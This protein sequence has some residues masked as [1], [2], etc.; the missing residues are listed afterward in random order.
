ML[1]FLMKFQYIK[2]KTLISYCDR[3]LYS[4]GIIIIWINYII[5]K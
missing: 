2:Q 1:P 5:K 3:L 4:F